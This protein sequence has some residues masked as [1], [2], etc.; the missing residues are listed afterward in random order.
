MANF[1]RH[2]GIELKHAR[3]ATRATLGC[4][5]PEINGEF[6]ISILPAAGCPQIMACSGY[7][8]LLRLPAF[9]STNTLTQLDSLSNHVGNTGEAA[10][11]EAQKA[12]PA[13]TRERGMR[14]KCP[15]PECSHPGRGNGSQ[16]STQLN[17]PGNRV[18]NQVRPPWQG[19]WP[20]T[21]DPDEPARQQGG[22]P[23]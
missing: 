20:T 2:C 4:I 5:T 14:T 7:R 22:Q 3:V 19:Q 17:L 15:A 8:E 9:E 13:S 11:A 12:C 16:H 21:L 18:G 6:P 1:D 23:K 10:L